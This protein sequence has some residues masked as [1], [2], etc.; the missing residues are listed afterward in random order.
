MPKLD[1][2]GSKNAVLRGFEWM[3]RR[4]GT[5]RLGRMAVQAASAVMRGYQGRNAVLQHIATNGEARILQKFGPA[6]EV[7]FDVGANEGEWTQFALEAGARKVHAFEISPATST[8]LVARFASDG[9]VTVN[10]FGLS[11]NAGTV[12]IRH[13]PDFPKL[14]TM[15]DF[16]WELEAE[17]IEVPVRTGDDYLAEM[18]IDRIDFLKLDV[19][20][21]EH[22]VLR[23]FTKAFERG[24]IGAVQFE[25][26]KFV[27]LTKYMLRDFY[28]DLTAHGFVLGQILPNFWEAKPFNLA[29]ET[30]TDANY[31]AVHES[32]TDLLELLRG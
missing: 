25:Y 32:R 1:P 29:M 18:G 13:F 21:A 4:G 17:E 23:G 30:L 14:T 28:A 19:E 10:T 6:L 11:E 7:V 26:G 9:R 15:T 3:G 8:D 5:T 16:P 31:L 12:T 22:S 24:A 2:R 27:V 20:G